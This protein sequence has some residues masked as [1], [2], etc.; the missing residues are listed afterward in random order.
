LKNT[1]RIVSSDAASLKMPAPVMRALGAGAG[2]QLAPLTRRLLM[3]DVHR[4]GVERQRAGAQSRHR[5]ERAEAVGIDLEQEVLALLCRH[6]VVSL[7][8]HC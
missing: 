5:D 2:Q 1:L 4:L 3:R 7:C 8:C 6:A